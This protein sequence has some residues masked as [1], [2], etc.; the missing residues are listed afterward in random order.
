MLE[1][2]FAKLKKF[3]ILA[4]RYRNRRKK[5]GLRFNILVSIYNLELKL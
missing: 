4:E 3:K 5:F 2:V 1:H